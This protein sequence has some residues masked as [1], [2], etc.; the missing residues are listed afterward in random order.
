MP[1]PS[2][3]ENFFASAIFLG[4][5]VF[6]SIAAF[7]KCL[8]SDVSISIQE[9]RALASFPK[10]HSLR[11]DL[12]LFA[13]QFSA[14]YDDRFP[15]RLQAI[16]H[17][18]LLIYTWFHSSTSPDCALGKNGWLFY[19]IEKLPAAQMNTEPFSLTKLAAWTRML[20]A[21]R[22]AL[23]TH[24]IK[25]LLVIA[26]EK[27]TIY[28]EFMPLGWTRE[29]GDGR[30]EQLQKYLHSHTNI[31]FVDA[32]SVLQSNK[33]KGQILYH[34][35]DS[36][37]NEYGSFLVTQAVFKVLSQ[38]F[39]SIQEYSKDEYSL[40][41]GTHT[42]DLAE[43]LGLGAK[44]VDHQSASLKFSRQQPA[45]LNKTALLPLLEGGIVESEAPGFAWEGTDNRLPRA[46]VMH[47]SFMDHMVPF[48]SQRFRFVEYQLVRQMDPN[49][50]FAEKPDLVI[51]EFAERHLYDRE[52]ENVPVFVKSLP[53]ARDDHLLA[54]FG[55]KFELRDIHAEPSKDGW[56]IKLL[57]RSKDREKLDY[58]VAVHA[59]NAAKEES[60]NFD[61][62]QDCFKRQVG[63]NTEWIDTVPV[64]AQKDKQPFQLG[65]MI[66]RNPSAILPCNA[67]NSD[68]NIRL[69]VPLKS[70]SE[71]ENEFVHAYVADNH[72]NSTF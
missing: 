2:S 56:T 18:N 61:Y 32:K 64:V 48:L 4:V 45:H 24:N 27:G 22:D 15:G 62:C 57:W 34:P 33:G 43:L 14:Y 71:Q 58:T 39:H 9:K 16:E 17:W 72:L 54:T 68:W 47:D 23:A 12:P 53:S 63:P 50:V 25:Y 5:L 49:V 41:P 46:F 69:L 13:P 3:A 70:A 36:H 6:F 51:D 8:N 59:L 52:P 21:R 42:G 55:D 29:P 60:G 31:D 20:Q 67:I 65:I 19:A 11:R 66:Y 1:K 7:S 44:L 26:P 40:A 38:H 28:P 30:L 10:M 37:W 35:N